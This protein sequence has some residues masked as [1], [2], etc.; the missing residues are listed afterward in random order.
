MCD[1]LAAKIR[2]YLSILGALLLAVQTLGAEELRLGGPG[3][4]SEWKLPGDAVDVADGVLKP[5]FVH[6]NID[7]VQNAA[8]FGGG[9]RAA[10]TALNLAAR[11]METT[12]MWKRPGRAR[13]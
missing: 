4:W 5:A 6:Q 1:R 8:L 11:L 3:G 2:T 12:E 10:G 7:A 13:R 9:I